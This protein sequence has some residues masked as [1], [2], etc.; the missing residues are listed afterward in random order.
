[1]K[2]FMMIGVL[3]LVFGISLIAGLYGDSW[4]LKC[5]GFALVG[6]SYG[7]AWRDA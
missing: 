2:V 1:M 3:C 4:G 6:L 5:L 7:F